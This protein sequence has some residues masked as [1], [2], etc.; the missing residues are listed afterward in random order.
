LE[1]EI[2][3]AVPARRLG[4]LLARGVHQVGTM[5]TSPR[6]RLGRRG[7]EAAA[8]EL[9][10]RGYAIL[11]RGY[12][13]RRGEIDLIAR[14]GQTVV[15][16]EVKTRVGSRF[17]GGA[18][19]VTRQKQ[20]RIALVAMDYLARHAW[21]ESPCRFDVAVVTPGSHDAAMDVQVITHAFSLT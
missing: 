5:A 20:R 14:D 13:T 1:A 8:Q 16:V 10:R 18:A 4:A 6:Q 3:G 7:E 21:L 2:E 12:R 19:A 15:F 11:A 9:L 17:G